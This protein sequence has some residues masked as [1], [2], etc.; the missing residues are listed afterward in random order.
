M[1]H[2]IPVGI[3]SDHGLIDIIESSDYT[4]MYVRLNRLI[5]EYGYQIINSY[6]EFS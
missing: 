3:K 1:Y 6:D 2:I 4:F 5:Y